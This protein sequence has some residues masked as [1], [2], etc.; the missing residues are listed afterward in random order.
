MPRRA[1]PLALTLALAAAPG[2]AAAHGEAAAAD[3]LVAEAAFLI[4]T[5]P[6]TGR[7]LALSLSS[8]G[9]GPEGA[10]TAARLQAALA[11][12]DRLGVTASAGLAS[13]PGSRLSLDAPALS[14]KWLLLPAASARTG[15]S[16]SLDVLSAPGEPGGAE[17]VVGVGALRQLGPFTARAALGVASVAGALAPHLH[18]G[19]SL[20][21]APGGPWRL[22]AESIGEWSPDR[23]E[24]SL[25]LGPTV[26]Y[27]LSDRSALAASLLVEVVPVLRPLSMVVQLTRAL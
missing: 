16:A 10:T 5:L 3:E 1:L 2:L 26:K 11:L 14:V 22:L 13:A 19:G 4:D 6:P 15:F 23:E 8:T 20:A 9:G 21:F 25:A 12:S 17:L 27:A 18:A 7:E 24:R